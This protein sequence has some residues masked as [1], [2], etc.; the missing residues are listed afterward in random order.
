MKTVYVKLS[1]GN[2]PIHIG[3][4]LLA[5]A[6]Y[7]SLLQ[8]PS[9]IIV[10]DDTVAPLYLSTLTN[11]LDNQGINF[12]TIVIP[13]GESYKNLE[14]VSLIL[15]RL[16][17]LKIERKTTL[18]ALGGGVIG[19]LAGFAAAIYLRGIPL[20]QI[21]TTLLSQADAS[22]GGKTGVNHPYSKNMIGAL[23]QPKAVIIDPDTLQTLSEREISSGLAEV[24][25][26]GLIQDASFLHWLETNMHRLWKHDSEALT[27]AIYRSCCYKAEAT[28]QDEAET[29]P[30][31]LLNIGHTFGHAIETA[32]GYGEWL[33]GE[34]VGAGTVMAAHL[35]QR[36]GWISSDDVK[37][38]ESLMH[39][40]RL[41]IRGPRLGSQRYLELM[42]N[43]KKVE[44]GRLRLI[45]L[46]KLGKAE[47]VTWTER[48]MLENV[49][50]H[51]SH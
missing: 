13:T 28:S 20:I 43:D 23:H 6:D 17:E 51:C 7:Q 12:E 35:S 32:M 41:P 24:I 49:I 33:H 11:A 48:T 39:L 50:H 36:A 38:V 14:T 18:I 21:P 15:D 16:L 19:D 42:Q 5:K 47:V 34:A 2:Y 1:Q 30:R 4:G 3:P 29:G 27:E 44:N 37:H 25:K 22:V 46:K 10:T 8:Q 9:A 45:L 26:F 40:A 31:L